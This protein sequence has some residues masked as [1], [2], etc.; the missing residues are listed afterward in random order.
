M[1]T[2]RCALENAAAV[3]RIQ[4]RLC[5]AILFVLKRKFGPARSGLVFANL[6]GVMTE[7]R[8]VSNLYLNMT[9]RLVTNA[10]DMPPLLTEILTLC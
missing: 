9:D 4:Q 5:D 7:L 1:H 8:S 10:A 2:D 6:V 3:E